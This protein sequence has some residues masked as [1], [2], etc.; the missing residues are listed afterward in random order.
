MPGEWKFY[1]SLQGGFFLQGAVGN[2]SGSF[3]IIL[4]TKDIRLADAIAI[5]NLPGLIEALE[6]IKQNCDPWR[7]PN[8]MA[9]RLFEIADSAIRR[10]KT[11]RQIDYFREEV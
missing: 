11:K 7:K 3:E 10:A 8:N 9:G 4:A 1:R 2:P 5:E 6:E